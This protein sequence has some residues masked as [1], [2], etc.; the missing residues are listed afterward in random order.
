MHYE[1]HKG[2]NL[3]TPNVKL[4][5]LLSP[6]ELDNCIIPVDMVGIK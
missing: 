1:S 5:E 2:R 4:R 3:G 6:Y